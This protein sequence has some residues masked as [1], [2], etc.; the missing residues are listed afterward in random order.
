MQEKRKLESKTK[1]KENKGRKGRE[2]WK[3]KNKGSKG[4]QKKIQER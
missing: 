3:E 1:G 4:G 2:K